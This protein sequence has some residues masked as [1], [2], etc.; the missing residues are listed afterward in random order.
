MEL[1]HWTMK[2]ESGGEGDDHSQLV[3]EVRVVK[4]VSTNNYHLMKFECERKET[5]ECQEQ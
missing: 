5:L 4:I 3:E 1:G 2:S